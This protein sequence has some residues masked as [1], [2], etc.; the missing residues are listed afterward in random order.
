M[1]FPSKNRVRNSFIPKGISTVSETTVLAG[2]GTTTPAVAEGRG[3]GYETTH[4][5]HA[6]ELAN[7]SE[8]F[9]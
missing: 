6:R 5:P 2:Y 9:K 8:L 3:L 4:T 1:L 7:I